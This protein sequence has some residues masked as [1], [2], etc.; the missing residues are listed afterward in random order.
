MN[1]QQADKVMADEM[2]RETNF[3]ADTYY[4]VSQKKTSDK[5]MAD[6]MSRETN[7][8]ADTYYTV[9]QKKTSPF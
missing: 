6:E 5:V 7:F 1:Q 9:S 3:R 2:S 8:R 4:T